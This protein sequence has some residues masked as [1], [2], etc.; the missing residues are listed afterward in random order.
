MLL[1]PITKK[2]LNNTK[3]YQNTIFFYNWT[4]YVPQE[5]LNQFTRETGIKIIYSTYESN[6]SMYAKLKTYTK[7]SYDLVVPSTYFVEKMKNEGM[8]QKIEKKK[9]PNFANLDYKFLNKSFDLKNEYSIPF[10]WGATAI[11]INTNI[12]KPESV[13]SWKDLWNPRYYKSISL[14]DDAKE[15]FQMSLIKLGYPANTNNTNYIKKSFIDLKK[16]MPNII[17]FNSDNPGY[18]FIEGSVNIGM[19]WNGSAYMVQKLGIPLKFIWPKEGGIFWMDSFV[20]PKN[21]K[22]IKGALKLINFLLRPDIAAK[23][24][25]KTGFSTPNL[26]AKKLLPLDMIN[27]EILYPNDEIINKGV[28]QNYV[29]NNISKRYEIDFQKLKNL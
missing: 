19:I 27:N 3:S 7:Q 24:A 2:Y 28:W 4:E 17:S 9:I 22:N 6:E 11:G 14:I 23:I 20:I 25:K 16:L 10:M 15:V 21:A 26:K 29:N 12:I 5:I 13:H 8:I 1:L 18:P